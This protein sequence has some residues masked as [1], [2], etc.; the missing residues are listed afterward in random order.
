MADFTVAQF[1]D[2]SGGLQEGQFAIGERKKAGSLEDLDPT[3]KQLLD[4]PI[5]VTLGL[6]GPDGRV[7]LTPMWFD[8]DG[9][10]VLVNTASHRAK[11]GWIRKNPRLTMLLV[12][13]QNPYHWMSIKAT[14]VNEIRE[15]EPTA[16][17]PASTSTACGRSTR[18]R[19]RPTDCGIPSS[20]KSAFCSSAAWTGWPRSGNRNPRAPPV[21]PAAGT[22]T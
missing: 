1:K 11:C 17:G 4:M 7:N 5:T 16:S 9:D 13:P 3:Y 10:K 6:T 20:T 14:V 15:G 19:S 12:N 21:S 18:A 2:V 8:Y 22:R